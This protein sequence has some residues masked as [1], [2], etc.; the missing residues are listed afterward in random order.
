MSVCIHFEIPC[1]SLETF[2]IQFLET[3]LNSNTMYVTRSPIIVDR[4]SKV[5]DFNCLLFKK[6]ACNRKLV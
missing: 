6:N 3:Y 2:G 1:F 5:Q 4:K